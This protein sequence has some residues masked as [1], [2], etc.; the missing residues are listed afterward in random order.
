MTMPSVTNATASSTTGP[1]T[2][3][4]ISLTISSASDR[5][6]IAIPA[7]YDNADGDTISSVTFDPGGGDEASF[8]H[9]T[10]ADMNNWTGARLQRTEVWTLDLDDGVSS[11][12]YTIRVT[13]S[14]G[15]GRI[16]ASVHEIA[17]ADNT[18][19]IGNKGTGSGNGTDVDVTVSTGT[20]NSLV[21]GGCS[22]SR[23]S[24]FTAGSGDTEESEF[25]TN[26]NSVWSGSTPASSTG[27][28]NVSAAGAGGV[29]DWAMSG[30]EVL[31]A[32]APASGIQHLFSKPNRVDVP[33][34]QLQ[35]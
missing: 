14:A 18:T 3:H 1:A 25:N 8:T 32:A 7:L 17:D 22:H 15:V 24:T 6:L 21:L 11:G 12:S 35:L 5:V 9:V 27:S 4:D 33:I 31:E 26:N 10:G 28:Y 13:A 2:S 34:H 23:D 16:G 20:A 19:P 30:V 29:G